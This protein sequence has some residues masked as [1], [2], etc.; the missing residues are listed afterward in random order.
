VRRF[1][2]IGVSFTEVIFMRF[3]MSE[4]SRGARRI[5]SRITTAASGCI[6]P[7]HVKIAV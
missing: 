5:S 6:S 3:P 7:A 1:T 2:A 4:E